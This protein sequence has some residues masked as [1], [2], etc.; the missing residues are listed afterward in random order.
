M[1]LPMQSTLVAAACLL[2]LSAGAAP[3]N[4]TPNAADLLT[5]VVQA[6]RNI[7]PVTYTSVTVIRKNGA[8]IGSVSAVE[9]R[10]DKTHSVTTGRMRIEAMELGRYRYYE[11]AGSHIT[12]DEIKAEY[13]RTKDNH[14]DKSESFL[15][16]IAKSLAQPKERAR[17]AR[18]PVGRATIDG[19]PAWRISWL[20]TDVP[21]DVKGPARVSVIVDCGDMLIRKFSTSFGKGDS[22]AVMLAYQRQRTPFPAETFVFTPPAGAKETAG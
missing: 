8:V 15:S 16:G 2:P 7:G 18:I 4:P 13:S 1:N 19:R 22:V 14:A 12:Y 17:L 21:K 3:V 6:S 5:K 11:N 10:N 9:K 20:E